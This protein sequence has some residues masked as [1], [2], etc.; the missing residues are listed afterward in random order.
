MAA[1]RGV[2]LYRGPSI[3]TGTPIVVVATGVNQFKSR[4]SENTKTG[5]MIQTWILADNGKDPSST[6][7]DK[8]DSSICGDCPH[9]G[10][11]CYVNVSQAPQ[12]VY[13]AH[14][15]GIYP[16][17]S[18]AEHR[19]LF[20]GRAM[21]FG[22]YGDPAAVPFDVWAQFLPI[23]P[24]RT[25]YTHQWRTCNPMFRFLCMASCETEQDREL[26]KTMGYRTF[27]VRVS[28]QAV[29]AGEV[30]CPASEE[31]GKRKTCEQ[32]NACTG[33]KPGNDL[34]NDVT[35]LI[36]GPRNKVVGYNNRVA[37]SVI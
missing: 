2:I 15:R 5:A 21:R 37:L 33:A 34:R 12:A 24:R 23:V 31:A 16:D 19:D 29:Q 36:H 4:H 26:A 11:S 1:I 8:E 6:V 10:K 27:R 17:Y 28:Y 32:C 30:I 9:K 18:P 3:L 20:K 35:I 14:K 7:R 25:G 22:S 13:K